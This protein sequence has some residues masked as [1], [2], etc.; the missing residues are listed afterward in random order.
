MGFKGGRLYK[1]EA[2]LEA[3][4]F[5]TAPAAFSPDGKIG[6]GEV[7]SII[8]AVAR[9]GHGRLPLYMSNAYDASR[10]HRFLDPSLIFARDAQ[11][12][13]LSLACL[14]PKMLVE[15]SALVIRELTC[16]Q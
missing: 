4:P 3:H 7:N 8:R 1:T 10:I 2:F 6:T 11:L 16:L 5:G 9:L 15:I 12:Y 13:P 14:L